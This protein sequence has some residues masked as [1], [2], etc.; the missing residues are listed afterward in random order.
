MSTAIHNPALSRALAADG[1][2]LALAF[3]GKSWREHAE[4]VMRSLAE[5]GREFTA[6]D[7]RLALLQEPE[8]HNAIGGVFRRALKAGII[9]DTGRVRR[10]ELVR[11][12]AR[13]MTIYVGERTTPPAQEG[14]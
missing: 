13:K 10:S 5:S 14:R 11:A 6:D 7:F 9:R 8:H 12:H 2:Q 4:G 3:S 1:M